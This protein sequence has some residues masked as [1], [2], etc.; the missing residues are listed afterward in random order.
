MMAKTV[1][2][3]LVLKYPTAKRQ[4]LRRMVQAG[5]VRV[6]GAVARTASQEVKDDAVLEVDERPA[7]SGPPAPRRRQPGI[8]IVYEDDD[9]LVVNKP[10][11]LLTSTG[12]RE[13]RPTLLAKVRAYAEP[14]SEKGSR[15]SAIRIGL[16]HR[17]DRDASGLLVFSKNDAA[18][19]S[20]K[21]QFFHHTVERLYAAVVHG[22]PHPTVGRIQTHLVERAD[23]KVYSTPEHG[24]GEWALTDYELVKSEKKKSLL[25]VTLQTGRKHQIRVHLSEKVWPI[26]GDTVYGREDDIAPRL[27]LAAVKLSLD[28]PRTEKRMTWEI[29]LP[30]E[31][32][33]QWK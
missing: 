33:L 19:R 18:Y 25:R 28:H 9:L 6:G 3:L 12:S 26:V 24:K 4:T 21:T 8:D 1:L 30:K 16:I 7:A 32:P 29:P 31:F 15:R 14:P 13:S 17:L 10:P 11:G 2:D 23:G 22:L 27:M 20:L 5:R